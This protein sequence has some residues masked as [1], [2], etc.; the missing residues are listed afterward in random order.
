M[1]GRKNNAPAARQARYARR[2]REGRA[3]YQIELG[4][5]DLDA[6]V[7]CGV[8]SEA[9]AGDRVAVGRAIAAALSELADWQ[10]MR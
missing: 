3:I 6:L 8:L 2:Q 4:A 7:A 10:K 9:Q 5:D 1:P